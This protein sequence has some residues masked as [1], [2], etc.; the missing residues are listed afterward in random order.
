MVAS[1]LTNSRFL[2]GIDALLTIEAVN[3][4]D[5]SVSRCVQMKLISISRSRLRSSAANCILAAA[6][7]LT[8]CAGPQLRPESFE[9]SMNEPYLLASGDRLRIIVYGQDQLSNSY[10]IDGSGRVSIPLV[11][12]VDCQGLTTGQLEKRI[13]T[14]LRSGLLRD[15]KIAVEVEQYR[16]FFVLGEVAQS[17]QYPFV[18]GATVQ[19][20]IAIAGGFGPRAARSYADVTRVVSGMATTASVPITFPLHP[21]DTITIKERFF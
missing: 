2:D 1:R 14:K 15:P 5:Y 18:N 19:T 10:L 3:K 12:L 6:L 7:A 11:G 13:E 20:A 9:A 17:G 16:P 4:H 21:G 8:G